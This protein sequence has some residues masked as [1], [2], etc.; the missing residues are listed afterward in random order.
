MD[1]LEQFKAWID[2]EFSDCSWYLEAQKNKYLH[3]YRQDLDDFWSYEETVAWLTWQ[4]RQAEINKLQSQINEMAEVGLSQESV[5]REKDKRIERATAKWISI[6][7]ILTT[8]DTGVPDAIF[9]Q[10]DQLHD[11]LCGMNEIG[12]NNANS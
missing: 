7:T 4:S 10:L 3:L 9:K 5:I 2:L 6:V 8:T 11:A 12:D 1:N